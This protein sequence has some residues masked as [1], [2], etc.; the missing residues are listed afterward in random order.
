MDAAISPHL[1]TDATVLSLLPQYA[2]DWCTAAKTQHPST[3]RRYSVPWFRLLYKI[4]KAELGFRGLT[5]NHTWDLSTLLNED[6]E[7]DVAAAL[8]QHVAGRAVDVDPVRVRPT[9]PVV[10]DRQPGGHLG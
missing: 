9:R 10:P 3:W 2:V 6:N 4:H 5:G 1:T 8:D 7:R